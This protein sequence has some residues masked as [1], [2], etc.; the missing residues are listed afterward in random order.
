MYSMT[1]LTRM[2]EEGGAGEGMTPDVA[3]R[4]PDVRMLRWSLCPPPP[5]PP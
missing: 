1:D 3:P 4:G 2:G 5:P